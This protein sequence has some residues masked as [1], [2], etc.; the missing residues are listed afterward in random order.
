MGDSQ[1]PRCSERVG[2]SQFPHSGSPGAGG[3]QRMQD[4]RGAFP[5]KRPQQGL[6]EAP[7]VGTKVEGATVGFQDS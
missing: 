1:A 3:G 7:E 6:L 5:D 4:S 2:E